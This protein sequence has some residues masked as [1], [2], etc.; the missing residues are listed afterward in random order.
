MG[1]DVERN[2][3]PFYYGGIQALVIDKSKNKIFGVADL[4]R[5]GKSMV[6]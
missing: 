6:K 2:S 1:Y 4:R 5:K 3:S